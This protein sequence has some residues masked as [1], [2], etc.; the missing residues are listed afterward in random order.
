[1]R[2]DKEIIH[3]RQ[4]VGKSVRMGVCGN[5]WDCLIEP[6][7]SHNCQIREIHAS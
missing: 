1:M 7:G 5:Y 6:S 2:L 3:R 4:G